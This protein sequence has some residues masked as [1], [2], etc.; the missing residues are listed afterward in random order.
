MN[1]VERAVSPVEREATTRFSPTAV[2]FSDFNEPLDDDDDYD[3]PVELQTNSQKEN[4]LIS[5]PTETAQ[6]TSN[7]EMEAVSTVVD[8]K[9]EKGLSSNWLCRVCA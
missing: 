1:F 7:V 9:V 3:G 6:D 5:V 4:S 2:D 8:G